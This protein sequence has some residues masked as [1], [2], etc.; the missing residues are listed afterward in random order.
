MFQVFEEALAPS[1]VRPSRKQVLEVAHVVELKDAPIV[2]GA[3]VARAEYLA[4]FERQHL[5]RFAQRIRDAFAIEIATPAAI[6]KEVPGGEG[7]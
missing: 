2:A 3:L 5:L 1:I 4:T 7:G 6:L